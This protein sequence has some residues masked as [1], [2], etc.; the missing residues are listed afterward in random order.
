MYLYITIG[1]FIIVI[2]ILLVRVY[3]KCTN[4]V[5][6]S[7]ARLDGKTALVTGGTAGMGLEIAKDLARRGARVIIACPFEQEGHTAEAEIKSETQND[8]VQYK[9]L[10]LASLKSVRKLASDILE[11][12]NRLDILVNNAGVLTPGDFMTEDGINFIMQVN[13][14]GHFLLTLLLVPLLKKSAPSRIVNTSSILHR[15]G[16]FRLDKINT[17]GFYYPSHVY[18]ISK[19]CVVPFSTELTKRLVGTGVVA[20]SIDPG[21]V[22]THIFDTVKPKFVGDIIRV[23]FSYFYKTANEGAQTAIQCGCG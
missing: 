23:F 11:T 22:G 2:V 20:N 21:A 9:H 3:Q 5:C 15:G 17:T 13:Y 7:E 6:T 19:F 1:V 4:G 16:I 14:F 10:D 18:C 8:N 12:E